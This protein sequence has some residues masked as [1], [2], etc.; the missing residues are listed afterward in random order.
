MQRHLG[1]RLVGR[2]VSAKSGIVPSGPVL[3][4]LTSCRVTTLEAPHSPARPLDAQTRIRAR[5]QGQG[6][7]IRK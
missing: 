5:Q 6:A 1:K 2:G 7:L 3:S 4:V